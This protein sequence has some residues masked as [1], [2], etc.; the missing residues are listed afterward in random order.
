MRKIIPQQGIFYFTNEQR[1]REP[2]S[3]KD[4]PARYI[5]RRFPKSRPF[6]HYVPERQ[7]KIVKRPYDFYQ[8][9]KCAGHNELG[10]DVPRRHECR[11]RKQQDKLDAM[12][13]IFE[14]SRNKYCD[15]RNIQYKYGMNKKRRKYTAAQR[16]PAQQVRCDET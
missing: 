6:K 3:G 12:G 1:G 2:H 5:V 16:I 13:C 11:D 14:K 4:Q 9:R 15:S 8:C 7:Y 10:P